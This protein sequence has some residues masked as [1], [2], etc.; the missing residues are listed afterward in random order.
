M[1]ENFIS[2]MGKEIMEVYGSVVKK[3]VKEKDDFPE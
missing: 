3:L 1:A 2:G